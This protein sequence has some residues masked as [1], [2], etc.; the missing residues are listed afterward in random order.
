MATREQLLELKPGDAVRNLGTG[1]VYLVTCSATE[2]QPAIAVRWIE[3][4]NEQEWALV[5][6]GGHESGVPVYG[7]PGNR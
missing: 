2:N 1:D 3:V 5:S 7:S 4:S 6:R